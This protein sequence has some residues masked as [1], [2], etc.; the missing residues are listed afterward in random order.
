M[1]NEASPT[2]ARVLIADDHSLVREG[3]RAMLARE[4]GLEVVGEAENGRQALE[5]CRELRPDLVLMD[6]RMPKLDG[7]AA[8]QAIKEEYPSIS[9]LIVTTHESPE[10]LMDAIRAGAAGYVLKDST[11]QELLD[12][13]RRVLDGESPLNQELAMQLLQRLTDEDRRQTERPVESGKK[14]REERLAEPLTDREVE[15]LRLLVL[16]KTNREVAQSLR[17]SLSTIKSHVQRLIT[18]L[19]VSDRTQAAVR[20]VELGLLAEQE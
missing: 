19:G 20:A 7:M 4:P 10:Y 5:M 1:K 14:R 15:V 18:K 8:T 11:K 12:A 6:V 16:G 2:P 9:V 13:V 17:L 3:M